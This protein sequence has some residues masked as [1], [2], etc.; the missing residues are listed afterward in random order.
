MPYQ[1]RWRHHERRRRRERRRRGADGGDGGSSAA[2]DPP[3]GG[4]HQHAVEE[5][6]VRQ[7][8]EK[9]ASRQ[10]LRL[11][12]LALKR[13]RALPPAAELSA[14]E[15]AALNRR[16]P[17][18][19][20][21][22]S[23]RRG[24]RPRAPA[25]RSPGQSPRALRARALAGQ[26][27]QAAHGHLAEGGSRARGSRVSSRKAT[28]TPRAATPTRRRRRSRCMGRA[29]LPGHATGDINAAYPTTVDPS[30]LELARMSKLRRASL[31]SLGG[32]ATER[33]SSRRSGCGCV[34]RRTGS[35][36]RSVGRR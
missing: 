18:G 11:A 32:Q 13:A 23:T 35:S 10:R 27:G 24:R 21:R 20:M 36:S 8:E 29:Y 9:L 30:K 17:S 33:P 7:I 15:E 4:D 34:G 28:A 25:G 1:R 3:R 26:V 16:S 14:E 22:W 31:P 2:R 6:R 5:A 12:E 19:W